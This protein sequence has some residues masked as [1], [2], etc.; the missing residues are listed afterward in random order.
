MFGVLRAVEH[1]SVCSN[2]KWWSIC[3]SAVTY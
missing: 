1:P 3:I 2:A